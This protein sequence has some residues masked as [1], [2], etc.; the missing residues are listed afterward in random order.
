MRKKL[1]IGSS[2]FILFLLFMMPIGSAVQQQ[3]VFSAFEDTIQHQRIQ[4][5]GEVQSFLQSKPLKIGELLEFLI[6]LLIVAAVSGT[7]L[8]FLGKQYEIP[9]EKIQ[10]YFVVYMMYFVLSAILRHLNYGF[11]EL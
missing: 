3:S 11:A 6:G 4:Q 8:S 5:F 1:L 9:E 7:T 2:V 10:A